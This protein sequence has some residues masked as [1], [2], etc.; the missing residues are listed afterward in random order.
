[1]MALV[2]NFDTPM[3]R[4]TL[5]YSDLDLTPSLRLLRKL[6]RRKSMTL[7]LTRIQVRMERKSSFC[8]KQMTYN[9]SYL[10]EVPA[11]GMNT[12]ISISL[13]VYWEEN[14]KQKNLFLSYSPLTI[15][16]ESNQMSFQNKM[17]FMTWMSF[18]SFQKD[19][20][21]KLNETSQ[22]EKSELERKK[23]T[24]SKFYIWNLLAYIKLMTSH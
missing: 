8:C 16:K 4:N 23:K 22:N 19:E 6:M 2:R 20:D 24:F 3:L 5:Q 14:E 12:E 15:L 21:L 18:M 1:M 11:E 13:E 10:T 7:T 9:L 17:L